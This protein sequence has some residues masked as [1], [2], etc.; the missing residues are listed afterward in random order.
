[1][2]RPTRVDGKSANDPKQS[3]RAGGKP[4]LSLA[5]RGF[6][7]PIG[8]GLRTEAAYSLGGLDVHHVLHLAPLMVPL[9]LEG[10]RLAR[11]PTLHPAAECT[12][13]PTQ[14]V[15]ALRVIPVDELRQLGF[16]HYLVRVVG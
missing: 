3:L 12:Q 15:A 7:L 13:R 2:H 10:P 16:P 8:R 4:R 11:V 5:K 1:M 6:P 14:P 9:G